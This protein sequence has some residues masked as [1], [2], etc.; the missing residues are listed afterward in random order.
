MPY[1]GIGGGFDR[2][3]WRALSSAPFVGADEASTRT[4]DA[5]P[6]RVFLRGDCSQ[7]IGGDGGWAGMA[8]SDPKQTLEDNPPLGFLR[9]K[10]L[11]SYGH[12]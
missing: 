9:A 4:A 11:S 12:A 10:A 5:S 7:L 8:V 6:T 1:R 3:R 2:V